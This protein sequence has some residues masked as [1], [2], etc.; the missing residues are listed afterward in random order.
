MRGGRDPQGQAVVSNMAT[1]RMSGGLGLEPGLPDAR[2]HAL[3]NPL[4][5]EMERKQLSLVSVKLPFIYLMQLFGP[6]VCQAQAN[7]VDPREN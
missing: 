3:N 5:A 1:A 7:T 4:P 6:T 2:V